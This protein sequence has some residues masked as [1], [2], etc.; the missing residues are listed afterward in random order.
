[1]VIPEDE[2]NVQIVNGFI[3]H[4]AVNPRQ[5]GVESP[6]G[7]WAPVLTL[8]EKS[9]LRYLRNYPD[10]YVVLLLDFDDDVDAR[11]SK[12]RERIPEEF[13][14]RV[15]ILGTRDEP[16]ALRRDIGKSLESI[17]KDLEDDCARTVSDHWDQAD[18]AHNVPEL[19]RMNPIIRPILFPGG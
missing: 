9:F 16:E 17:G 5:L 13:K 3:Q 8:F 2:A 7:G 12:C 11:R 1:M 18:L 15:F 19:R 6:A 14:E 4:H 10:G